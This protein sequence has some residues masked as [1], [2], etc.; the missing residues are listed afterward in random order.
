M[1]FG[2]GSHTCQEVRFVVV[3][4]IIRVSSLK[5]HH[6]HYD[7]YKGQWQN[8]TWWPIVLVKDPKSLPHCE[9][10]LIFLRSYYYR[11]PKTYFWRKWVSFGMVWFPNSNWSFFIST[12]KVWPVALRMTAVLD[13][14]FIPFHTGCVFLLITVRSSWLFTFSPFFSAVPIF[15][16]IH[17]RKR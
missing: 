10:T 12:E 5:D 9:I 4:I 14:V 7:D 11:C 2:L 6:H 3:I 17:A 8:Q 16:L 1:V 15:T 13:L